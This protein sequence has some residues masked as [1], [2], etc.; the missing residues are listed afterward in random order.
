MSSIT[1]TAPA[2]TEHRLIWQ[3]QEMKK[4]TNQLKVKPNKCACIGT[5]YRQFPQELQR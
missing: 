1:L 2:T 5:Q 3:L 4:N